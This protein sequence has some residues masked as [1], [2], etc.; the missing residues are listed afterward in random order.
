MAAAGR[1]ARARAP[2]TSTAPP[3]A[4]WTPRP[5]A[6]QGAAQPLPVIGR[7]L[8]NLRA[9]VLD[10]HLR[11]CPSACRAS[12]TSPAR[13]WRA[14]TWAGRTSPPSAS[15]RTRSAPRPARGCTAR[16][17]RRAGARTARWSSWAALDF[18]VKLRGFRIELGEIEAALR[19]APG[20]SG[21]RW[22]LVREDVPGD[23]RLVAY[24][25][26]G[27]G[28]TPTPLRAHLRKH[29]ARVHGARRLRG[30]GRPAADA[31]RQGG[32]Q[33][34]A[35][36]GSVAAR[37]RAPT[38]APRDAHGERRWPRSGA[39]CCASPAW[40]R[41]TT[42]SSWAATR[43]WPRRWCRAS[44]PRFGVELPL[45]ALFEAPTVAALAARID[46]RQRPDGQRACRRCVRA[47][48]TA[49]LPL[50]FAQQRLWFL[51]QLAAGQRALQ[52]ARRAAAGRAR[53]T[54]PRCSGAFDELVR[55]H[56]A[57]RTTFHV[58][59]RRARRRSSTRASPVPLRLVDLTRAAR[60]EQREAEARRLAARGGAHARSTWPGPAAARARC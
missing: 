39:R 6:I 49:A 30:P 17:T 58:A 18:Q 11:R 8:A 45:R 3:S 43:C 2:S 10:A 57:L 20:A 53:W 36:A 1:D 21:T 60:R 5:G 38:I 34:P 19:S 7:P 9:Y 32:P 46:S 47:D 14:A 22:S 27:A 55:R 4:P 41:T 52:H 33:G 24:V 31:Q 40:A 29:A 13:A 59:G 51:D 54:W 25:V 42:S 50:S 35:R 15:C 16:A 37:A 23:T 48:R 12:C 28:W 56:E 26:A 44:A